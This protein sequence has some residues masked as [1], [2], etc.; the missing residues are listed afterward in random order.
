[1]KTYTTALA[2]SISISGTQDPAKIS[3]KGV[4]KDFKKRCAQSKRG[5]MECWGLPF[6]VKKVHV[7]HKNTASFKIKKLK[8]KW[9]CFRHVAEDFALG[10]DSHA[11][12]YENR[13]HGFNKLAQRAATY[14]IQYADGSE[15]SYEIKYRHQIN[16]ANPGWGENA[17]D[18]VTEDKPVSMSGDAMKELWGRAQTVSDVRDRNGFEYINW[19]CAWKNPHPKKEIIGLRLESGLGTVILSGLVA[20]ECDETPLR[21]QTRKKILVRSDT[22][23]PHSDQAASM[24]LNGKRA[25]LVQIDMGTVIS[26][27]PRWAY[28]NKNWNKAP[29]HD[30]GSFDQH[31]FIVEYAAHPQAQLHVKGG[32]II[33]A[34][35]LS[36]KKSIKNGF[37][38]NHQKSSSPVS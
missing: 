9:L 3:M 30:I 25:E 34:K 15:V 26:V 4:S 1:M 28:Q 23:I 32:G 18:A 20:C 16:T 21:W 24:H 8:T 31:E 2:K 7:L 10:A 13:L 12:Q 17:V 33:E 14:H 6:D 29:M 27:V 5:K 22:K 36:G 38:K 35:Q 11:T 37:K 19:I